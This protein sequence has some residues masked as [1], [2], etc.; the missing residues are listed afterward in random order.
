MR[1]GTCAFTATGWRGSFYPRSL[2]SADFLRFYAQQFDTVELDVTF[3]Q[4]PSPTTVRGWYRKTPPG[5]VLAAK[6]PQAITHEKC[7]VNCQPEVREFLTAMERLGEKL[8][9]LLFQFPYHNRDKFESPQPFLERLE[10]FLK[11]LPKDF[12]YAVEVRNKWWIGP[13]L[14]DLLGEQG[15]ALALIDH[16][17]MH[18]PREI[19]ARVDPVTAPFTYIR[20][21]GDRH[22]IEELTKSWDKT[23]VDRS[24]EL[25]EW[26][27]VCQPIRRRGATIYGYV[28]NHFA[29]HAPA[30]VRTLR[31]LLDP[32]RKPAGSNLAPS[33]VQGQLF[34]LA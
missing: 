25:D 6:V 26:A 34:D 30:T 31:A 15:V 5:F 2:R 22:G 8:G 28:N 3:Y 11:S 17:W 1:L 29:G 23:I 18:R 16:P 12:R 7:L 21:L 20:W 13:S 33:P 14:V 27:G 19:V 10:A 24:E 9:P 32:D 4:I